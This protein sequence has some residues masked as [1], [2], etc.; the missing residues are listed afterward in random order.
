MHAQPLSTSCSVRENVILC[1]QG[2]NAFLRRT[3]RFQPLLPFDRDRP[4]RRQPLNLRG[5]LDGKPRVAD[6]EDDPIA[7]Y[8]V[9]CERLRKLGD[10]LHWMRF[11]VRRSATSGAW[12]AL[13]GCEPHRDRAWIPSKQV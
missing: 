1:S 8:I 3:V 6:L 11:S 12:P 7:D 2:A 13:R 9:S 5:P 10:A 4:G